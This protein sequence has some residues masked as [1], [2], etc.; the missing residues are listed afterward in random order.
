MELP[1]YVTIFAKE[2]INGKI[3]LELDE[4]IL[5]IELGLYSS[6][7]RKRLMHVVRGS[8]HVLDIMNNDEERTLV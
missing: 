3:F 6:L 7:H 8:H 1:Q 2:Q 4:V 5:E